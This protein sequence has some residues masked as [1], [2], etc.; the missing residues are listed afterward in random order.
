MSYY[1]YNKY[2]VIYIS[3]DDLYSENFDDYKEAHAFVCGYETG[4]NCGEYGADGRNIGDS[5]A[6]IVRIENIPCP[7]TLIT[8]DPEPHT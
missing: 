6:Y 7:G 1:Y 8:I 5:Q 4:E 3:G 2:V